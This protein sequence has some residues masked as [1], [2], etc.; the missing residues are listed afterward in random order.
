MSNHA[1]VVNLHFNKPLKQSYDPQRRE[2]VRQMVLHQVGRNTSFLI[3][4]D[5]MLI[6][7]GRASLPKNNDGWQAPIRYVCSALPLSLEMYISFIFCV[8]VSSMGGT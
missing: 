8:N 4:S 2:I 1:P 3:P 6:S 7:V 5:R